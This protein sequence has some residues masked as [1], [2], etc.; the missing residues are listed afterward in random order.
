MS[1]KSIIP[2]KLRIE[3][4]SEPIRFI[5][6]HSEICLKST[7]LSQ[8]K[9]KINLVWCKS[10]KNQFDSIRV[11]PTFLIL[12][13]IHSDLIR[14]FQSESIQKKFLIQ[15]NPRSEWFKLTSQSESIQIIPTSDSSEFKNCP[16]SFGFKVSD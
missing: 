13:K 12:T 11:N 8:S 14:D 10:V 16:K 7:H 4:H 3:I 15:M 2:D 6:I 9:K 5:P 1:K